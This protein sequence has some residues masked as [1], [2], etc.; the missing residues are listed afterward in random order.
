[1]AIV[2]NKSKKELK[3]VPVDQ[4]GTE[5]PFSVTIKALDIKTLLTL[6]DAVVKREGESI[7]F[8]MG[9]YAFDVCKASMV[10]WENINDADGKGLEFK[11]SADG[12]ALD[13]TVASIGIEYIQE[14]SSVVTAISRDSSKIQ[15]FFE[16]AE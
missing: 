12:I 9:R 14:I 3:Y 2:V 11:K 1:M 8:S 16:E 4:K 13:D 15:V 6:E 5:N 10:G 7:S